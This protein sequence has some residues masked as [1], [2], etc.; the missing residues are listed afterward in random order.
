ME[1]EELVVY[2][3]KK[4]FESSYNMTAKHASMI[5]GLPVSANLVKGVRRRNDL[6]KN[7]VSK[8]PFGKIRTSY[9]HVVSVD[10]VREEGQKIFGFIQDKTKVVYHHLAED[11]TAKEAL[12]GLKKYIKLYGRPDAVRC[13]NGSEFRKEFRAF[14]DKEGIK[15]INPLPYNPKANGFIERY[16]RT[17]RKDVFRKLKKTRMKVTQ[18]ILDDFAFIWNHCRSLKNGEVTT[19]AQLAGIDFPEVMS[20]RFEI[21]KQE[22]AG[23]SF[24]HISGVHGLMHAFL[25]E[26]MLSKREQKPRLKIA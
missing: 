13:D 10:V 12:E 22:V 19:P 11:Q 6:K 24:W 17:L 23:W 15:A 2:L 8:T 7:Q 9:D 4:D 25:P 18:D 1:M 21:E 5:S 20:E 26:K 16:F 14:L 3:V